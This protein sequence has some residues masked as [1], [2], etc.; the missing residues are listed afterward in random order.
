VNE[1]WALP[2]T[3]DKGSGIGMHGSGGGTQHPC[4]RPCRHIVKQVACAEVAGVG[5]AFGPLMGRFG[6]RAQNKVCSP[7]P[8]LL[9]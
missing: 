9:F 8:A 1:A 6:K 3:L 7:W 5:G 2:I 4:T